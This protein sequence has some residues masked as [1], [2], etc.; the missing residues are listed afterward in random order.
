MS[1]ITIDCHGMTVEEAGDTIK[2][3]LWSFEASGKELH[4]ITG[5]GKI[6]DMLMTF[7]LDSSTPTKFDWRFESNNRGCIIVQI[8]EWKKEI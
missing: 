7:L 2:R 4:V 3:Y 8:P 1:E 6:R 5:T